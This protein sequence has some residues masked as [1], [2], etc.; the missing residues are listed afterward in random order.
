MGSTSERE[1]GRDVVERGWIA[2][3][4]LVA[5]LCFLHNIKSLIF[6]I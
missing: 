1:L 5:L 3:L 4:G 2:M 6:R